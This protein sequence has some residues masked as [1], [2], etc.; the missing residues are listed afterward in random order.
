MGEGKNNYVQITLRL[1]RTFYSLVRE[2]QQKWGT[3]LQDTFIIILYRYFLEE[4]EC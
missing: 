3:S 4:D 2:R 1:P